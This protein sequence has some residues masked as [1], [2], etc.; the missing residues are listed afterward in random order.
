[1]K[2]L[3]SSD[4]LVNIL[5]NGEILYRGLSYEQTAEKL[6]EIASQ[7]YDNDVYDPTLIKI[8]VINHG[9]AT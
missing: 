7:I 1:M 4:P 5:Y 2:K 3:V 6:D 8:E 9:K